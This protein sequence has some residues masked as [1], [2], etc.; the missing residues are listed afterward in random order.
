MI[1]ISSVGCA[2]KDHIVVKY[3]KTYITVPC[4]V[5]KVDCNR[6]KHTGKSQQE[7]LMLCNR[8]LIKAN[9]GCR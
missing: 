7:E 3:K 6:F 1:G 9:E 5:P 4:K 8:E 2:S